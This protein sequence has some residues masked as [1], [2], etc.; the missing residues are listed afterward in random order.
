MAAPHEGGGGFTECEFFTNINVTTSL[1]A[2]HVRGRQGGWDGGEILHTPI[3]PPSLGT[4]RP[5]A[6]RMLE[7]LF[8]DDDSSGSEDAGVP[9]GGRAGPFPN[10]QSSGSQPQWQQ[11]VADELTAL[12]AA[13]ETRARALNEREAALT[14]RETRLCRRETQLASDDGLLR[15]VLE[16]ES[17]RL[18]A[19]AQVPASTLRQP[20]PR[21]CLRR[22]HHAPY[23]HGSTQLG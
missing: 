16:K 14:E 12:H 23:P 22:G 13:L 19:D 4:V 7:V 15:A 18:L 3:F 1:F 5:R 10:A 6:A 11:H 2:M 9:N 17:S 20:W 8:D 21:C